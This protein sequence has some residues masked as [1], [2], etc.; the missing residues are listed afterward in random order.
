MFRAL[1]NS[2]GKLNNL[3]FFLPVQ[4]DLSLVC[5]LVKFI[6]D[7]VLFFLPKKKA[8]LPYFQG[9]P[10]IYQRPVVFRLCLTA[11]LALSNTL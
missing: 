8:E 2:F 1:Y 6:L 3:D 5:L 10:A 4:C 7:Q 11:G 9:N